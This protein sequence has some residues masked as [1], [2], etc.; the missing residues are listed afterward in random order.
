MGGM[1]SQVG[2]LG[3]RPDTLSCANRSCNEDTLASCELLE[4]TGLCP[5]YMR[6]RRGHYSSEPAVVDLAAFVV[7]LVLCATGGLLGATGTLCHYW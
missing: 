1:A 2:A 7:P 5:M 4:V 3:P 6:V